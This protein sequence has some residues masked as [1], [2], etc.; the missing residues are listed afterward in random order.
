[1]ADVIPWIAA[2]ATG[3]AL[4]AVF[5][6]AKQAIG[7]I[8]PQKEPTMKLAHATD[9]WRIVAEGVL[10]LEETGYEIRLESVAAIQVFRIY[11]RG[12]SIEW[13]LRLEKA[14]QTTLRH[15]REMTEMGVE[16]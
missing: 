15:M 16:P 10:T 7:E 2:V 9:Q 3:C 12:R 8:I 11:H 5:I 4:G 6:T 14:K 13:E 1:M